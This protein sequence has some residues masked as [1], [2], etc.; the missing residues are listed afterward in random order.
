MKSAQEIITLKS[1]IYIAFA[2]IGE[3]STAKE[4]CSTSAHFRGGGFSVPGYV[5]TQGNTTEKP[6]HPYQVIF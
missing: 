5:G 6:V 4:G 1:S 2:G 3:I